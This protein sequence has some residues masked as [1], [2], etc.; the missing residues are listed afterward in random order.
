MSIITITPNNPDYNLNISSTTNGSVQVSSIVNSS[1]IIVINQGVGELIQGP[2]GPQGPVGPSGLQGATG[3]QG[4][5]GPAGSGI[6][7]LVA[8]SGIIITELDNAYTVSA[9]G[10]TI[11]S[12]SS[13]ILSNN[14]RLTLQSN[15]P[16]YFS[17]ISGSTLYF[18][19][20][21]GNNISLYDTSTS[22]WITYQFNQI[23]LVL[24]GMTTNTNYDIFLYHNGSNLVLENTAWST[25]L[26]RST[27]IIYQNG[28]LV[29]SGALN[30][31][32][33]GTIRS[34]SS[35]TTEDSSARRF[36]YN[37]NNQIQK[38][39]SATDGILHT[40]TSSIIRPYRNISTLGV[41][42]LEFICG[43]QSFIT[44]FCNSFFVTESNSSSVGI[45]LDSFSSINTK[46]ANTTIHSSGPALFFD[47]NTSDIVNINE[48]F[49]YL[50][51]LQYGSVTT[52]FYN[53]SFK[54]LFLC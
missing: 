1:E 17:D 40:Y 52:T 54:G 48:G 37:S 10:S 34:T 23:S 22:S 11:T 25:D 43:L 8:G 27:N 15:N 20:Y 46:A 38:T 50:Q 5:I 28:V 18:T 32:Y 53:S 4:P 47:N 7:T 44:L 19:P 24:S 3:P 16:T 51:L 14:G 21:V 2:P 33:I 39:L 41:T 9:S 13:D 12:L 42:K 31:R 26:L 45:G 30:K 49:H 29:K 36:V 6:I 35:N